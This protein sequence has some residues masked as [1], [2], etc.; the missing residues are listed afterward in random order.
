[1]IS[2]ELLAGV[3]AILVGLYLL[4]ALLEPERF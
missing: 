1:M 2:I 4:V 3:L